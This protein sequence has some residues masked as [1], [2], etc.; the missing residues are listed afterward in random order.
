[1]EEKFLT[2]TTVPGIPSIEKK[3][4]KLYQI[5]KK[6]PISRTKGNREPTPIIKSYSTRRGWNIRVVGI[7]RRE[8]SLIFDK[9]LSEYPLSAYGGVSM[10]QE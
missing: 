4:K 5:K 8:L 1:M 10:L 6:H 7:G 9:G 3:K 2:I